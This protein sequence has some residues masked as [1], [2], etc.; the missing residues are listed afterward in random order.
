[1]PFRQDAI[2]ST[3]SIKQED[4]NSVFRVS[5]HQN[6]T[7]LVASVE[8]QHDDGVTLVPNQRDTRE[9]AASAASV[10]REE[11]ERLEAQAKRESES[12]KGRLKP[13]A[14]EFLPTVT[15]QH[16]AVK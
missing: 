14:S 5:S 9:S 6:S 7:E 1:M 15:D 4:H 10:E 11:Q 16:K 8:Q 2:K 12:A 3:V 13:E